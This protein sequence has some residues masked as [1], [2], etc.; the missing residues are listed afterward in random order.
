MRNC[1]KQFFSK[2]DLALVTDSTSAAKT[3]AEPAPANWRVKY[4]SIQRE[5]LIA[6]YVN[7]KDGVLTCAKE[8][9]WTP[10]MARQCLRDMGVMRK[11][12]RIAEEDYAILKE[13]MNNGLNN[14]QIARKTGWGTQ[15]VRT[16]KDNLRKRKEA[17][18]VT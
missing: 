6:R 15:R 8:C 4:D 13:H 2:A 5:Q 18:R 7:S 1:T 16:L 9:G 11:P 10:H 12:K 17:G 3:K 14:E